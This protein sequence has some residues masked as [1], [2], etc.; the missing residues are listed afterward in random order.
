MQAGAVVTDI[1]DTV[2]VGIRLVAVLQ[3]G[4]VVTGI[5]GAVTV[6]IGLVAVLRVGAVV[7]DIADTVTVG[8]SLVGVFQAGAVVL[9]VG[10]EVCVPVWKAFALETDPLTRLTGHTR[11]RCP[12]AISGLWNTA[13]A[14]VVWRECPRGLTLFF[15]E[16]PAILEHRFTTI[17]HLAAFR[18]FQAVLVVT[19]TSDTV[20]DIEPTILT[21]SE[22]T[23]LVAPCDAVLSIQVRGVTV[24]AW[25]DP[26]VAADRSGAFHAGQ[27]QG[28]VV[29][30]ALAY[31]LTGLGDTLSVIRAGDT[32]A[33]ICL[34]ASTG[35]H[36][37]QKGPEGTLPQDRTA[38]PR[39]RYFLLV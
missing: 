28:Y 4:A 33:D 19:G 17:A 32:C 16:T 14:F 6:G 21:A 5:A 39:H 30:V 23:G 34:V 36:G 38:Y 18:A 9:L 25:I 2:S 1:A 37:P 22:L 10:H 20:R 11:Q 29:F 3:A 12:T 13:E 15:N 24:L 31:G 26:E 27:S 7:T 8:I 35:R